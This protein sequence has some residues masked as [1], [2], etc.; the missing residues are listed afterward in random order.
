MPKQIKIGLDKVPAPVT[1]QFTQ[2]I[3][4]EGNLL[5]DAAG[6]PVITED[7]ATLGSFSTSAGA[8]SIYANNF[9]NDPVISVPIE[10]Q[11][12]ETSEVSSS[13][14][15]VPR[16]EEQLSLFSDVSTYGLDE[17][18]W[19]YYT[20]SGTT[21]PSEWYNKENPIYG[22]RS[23]PT[24]N[25]GSEEQAL[26]L[27]SFPSQYGFPG[28]TIAENLQAPTTTM[29]KYINFIAVGRYLHN[30]FY[31]INPVFADNNFLNSNIEVVDATGNTVPTG[32]LG[33]FNTVARVFNGNG[34]FHDIEYGSDFKDSCN[35]IE[36]WTYFFGRIID[37]DAIFPDIGGGFTK[38]TEYESIR[39]FLQDESR[40]GGSSADEKFAILESQ[41]TFRYQPGR[42][43]GFTFGVRQQTDT[44]SNANFIEWGCSND[45]D[46]Y[47]FQLRGSEFNIIRRSTI[48][49]PDALLVR[50]GLAAEDQSQAPI[51]PKGVGT[52]P[53]LWET[54]IPRTKFN[55]DSMLG[56]GRSGYIL[57]FEDVTMYKIEFSWYGAI[58]AKFYAYA[59]A[60]VGEA[61]WILMHTFV[62]ENGLGK[63]VLNNPDFK[64]KYLIYAADTSGMKYPIFLYKYGSSYY[65]DGGDEGTINLSSITSDTKQFTQKTPILGVLP[66]QVIRNSD[67]I[68]IPNF[69]KAYPSTLSVTSDIATRVDVEVIEGS[70]DGVHYSYAPSLQ[71][72]NHALSTNFDFKFTSNGSS[73]DIL[74]GSNAPA[75]SAG[76]FAIGTR[77]KI[78]SLG[79]TTQA[80]WN[81]AAGT[82]NTTYSV[83]SYFMAA[84]VGIGSGTAK[85]VSLGLE[86]DNGKIIA[87]GVYNAY[88]NYDYDSLLRAETDISRKLDSY[89]STSSQAITKGLKAD[90][91]VLDTS[92]SPT[93]TGK[94]TNFHTVATSTVPIQA[95][96][97]KVHWLNPNARAYGG[98][99][100]A[101]YAI[102]IGSDL[103][104]VDGTDNNKLKFY[105]DDSSTAP[106]NFADVVSV[107]GSQT[108]TAIDYST[109]AETGEWDP[110]Y[111]QRFDV[112][113]RLPSPSGADAGQISA[114][115]G[116]VRLNDYPVTSTEQGTGNFASQYKITFTT[117]D[118]S[119]DASMFPVDNAGNVIAGSSELGVNGVGLG[120]Y[121]TTKPAVDPTT[122]KTFV[123]V[124]Q[125]PTTFGGSRTIT[126][127]QTKTITITDDWQLDTRFTA[128]QFSVSKAMKFNAQPLY[129]TVAMHDSAVL[130][131]IV[132]EEITQDS[133][134]V[135]TPV[136]IKGDECPNLTV[137]NSGDAISGLSSSI[138][139]PSAFN[140]IDK[141]S[142]LRFDT[143]TLN[144]LR[145][146]IN[147]YSF[148]IPSNVPAQFDLS[149][150][151]G[152]DRKGIA[153][154]LLNNKATFFNASAVDGTSVG[155]IEMTLTMKEQ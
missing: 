67:G 155:D 34:N 94:I 79:N 24:F 76:S 46:E 49:M 23:N 130:N 44:S 70:P 116:E 93:F 120:I 6:N 143:Q 9:D 4:I 92:T 89:T 36:R 43:S 66:K 29:Q 96:T 42:A 140:P 82:S 125:D 135:K 38:T 53:A 54:I 13:L 152:R 80:Q 95:N 14:L 75:I 109:K 45:T 121:Y 10:E 146:G 16:A 25:E 69:K 28:S 100:F 40:P 5:Y 86:D 128:P 108:G 85:K 83:G 37:N 48:P 2:L 56:N 33:S 52:G 26:Y 133:V 55:G 147:L 21:Y 41:K 151:F 35:Q 64:F 124:D 119:P 111:G 59:P 131:G 103:G 20:F 114:V 98:K 50:Q 3:D 1:K 47:M 139:S 104:F 126:S 81:T 30:R 134:Q 138:F 142:S 136:W 84:A 102:C 51:K 15:G 63:P 107:I 149:N 11:F 71:N 137:V 60:S 153:R 77:Y 97:F 117:N 39:L 150:I 19:N 127:V 8:T 18:N 90:G 145:P 73:I 62:I 17:D 110:S 113:V 115:K 91:T 27:R 105:K 72:G 129:L 87:D 118:G 68:G 65:V 61:R 32:T 57:S 12:N 31:S 154:G 106:F 141:Q 88:V 132:V 144:P 58:G 99:H 123:Y 112:D 122:N 7:E 101:E 22:A 74:D 148:Y 78:I